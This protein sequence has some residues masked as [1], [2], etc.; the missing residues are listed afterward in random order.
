[1]FFSKLSNPIQKAIFNLTKD[2]EFQHRF[3]TDKELDE[4]DRLKNDSAEEFKSLQAV[5]G[6]E[7]SISNH[8]SKLLTPAKWAFLWATSSPFATVGKEP[9][10]VDIDYFLYILDNGIEDGDPVSLLNKSLNY[11]SRLRNQL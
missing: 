6:F 10:P 4:L 3:A 1:M 7:V 5:L 8:K 2:K 9:K 11:V